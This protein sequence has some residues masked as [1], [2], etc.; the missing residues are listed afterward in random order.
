M[1]PTNSVAQVLERARGLTM[2]PM[3]EAVDRLDPSIRDVVRYHLGWTAADGSPTAVKGGKGIRA[4][5]PVLSAEAAWADAEVGAAGGVAVELVHNFSLIH[6]DLMDGDLERRHR[7]TVWALWGPAV[8]LIAGDALSTLGT[9]VLLGCGNQ[10]G[11]AAARA[12]GEATAEMIA[13]Q[14]M[15][16]AFEKRESV[17]VEECMAMS[18]A[19]TG[20]LLGCAASIGAVLAGAPPTTVQA[21]R[22]FGRHLGVAFQAVDDLLGIWGDPAT[23]G[24]PAGNDVRQRKKSMPI[25]AALA[26]GD[27]EANE[28]RALLFEQ[29]SAQANG[30][31]HGPAAGLPNWAPVPA[32]ALTPEEVARATWLVEAC[33][34][35]EWTAARAKAHLDA[36]L[37]SLERA[38]LSAVPRRELADLAVYAVERES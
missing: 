13:G 37:G 7:P 23:T 1:T 28:L 21:L 20:A 9:E 11:P 19:K 27:D 33:G 6:D 35:R 29:S 32:R 31:A 34:G 4:A 5:L 38:R 25:V 10:A 36:G 18:T 3:R 24:K 8:A 17:S 2:P 14:A 26:A 30:K 22:D 16:L 12:L 15:D